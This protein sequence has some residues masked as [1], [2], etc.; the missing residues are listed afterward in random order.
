VRRIAHRTAVM[1]KGQLVDEGPTTRIFKPPYHPY[2]ENLLA[3]VPEM[4]TDWLESVLKQRGGS[5]REREKAAA[6]V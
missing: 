1:L 3:S 6:K 2:T 4:R 5:K